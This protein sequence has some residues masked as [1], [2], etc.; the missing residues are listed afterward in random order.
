M[1]LCFFLRI[2][3]D[4]M[5]DAYIFAIHTPLSE[6]SLA[7]VALELLIRSVNPA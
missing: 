4:A 2:T 6:E 1:R 3:K 5:T 7:L